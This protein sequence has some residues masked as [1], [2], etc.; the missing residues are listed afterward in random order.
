MMNT[1]RICD[2]CRTPI[3]ESTYLEVVIWND[4]FEIDS[5]TRNFIHCNCLSKY[6]N[7]K[8]DVIQKSFKYGYTTIKPMWR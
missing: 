8:N 7:D 4:M 1:E 6:I 5:L 3:K 2:C